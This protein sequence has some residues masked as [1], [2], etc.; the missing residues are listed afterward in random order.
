MP[1]L[2]ARAALPGLVA[3]LW[4]DIGG[5]RIAPVIALRDFHAENLIWL[6]AR[7][8]VARVGLLDFQDAVAAHPAYDLVSLLQDARRDVPGATEADEIA[9]YCRLTDQSASAFLP[10]YH[11][12]GAQRALRILGVFARLCLAGGKDRY[13]P[14]LP[15]VWAALMRNLADPALAPLARAARAGLAEPTPAMIERMRAECGSRPPR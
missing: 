8:G 11:L 7:Q 13:L 5:D 1:A 4:R 6:P 9:R 3:D 12:L 2:D 14:Y 15:R 10:A